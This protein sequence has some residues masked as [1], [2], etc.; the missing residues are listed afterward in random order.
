MRTRNHLALLT[1]SASG[2]VLLTSCKSPSID[3]Q[4]NQLALPYPAAWT[5]SDAVTPHTAD[6]V[7]DIGLPGL[8]TVV[9]EALAN[10]QDLAAAAA[11]MD[12]ALANA[13]AANGQR[14]PAIGAGLSRTRSRRASETFDFPGAGAGVP[15]STEVEATQNSNYDLLANLSWE[16]D[17]WGRLRDQAAAANANYEATL[18]DLVA[19]E[20][21]IAANAAILWI[22]AAAANE[23][24]DLAEQTVESFEDNLR[25]IEDRY[26][27]GVTGALDVRLARTNV[28]NAQANLAVQRRQRDGLLR[29]L[30]TILGRYPEAEAAVLPSRPLFAT[31]LAQLSEPV[32]A[33]LP[34]GLLLRRPDLQSAERRL[35]A[36]E[37]NLT[38]TKKTRLPNISLTTAGGTSTSELGDL[39]DTDFRFWSLG[40]D[41]SVPIFQGGRISANIDRAE[42][43]R[44]EALANF[45]Q[46]ALTAFREVETAL[47]AGEFLADLEEADA[48]AVSES[49]AAEQLA[50]DQYRGGIVD[51]ITVLEAQ[52]RLF[53]SR[54]QLIASR[55]ERLQ[56]RINLYLALGGSPD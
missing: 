23:Q 40:L 8:E 48:L 52:R 55:S 12:Q 2:I 5:G 16:I 49:E 29:S 31:T 18:N 42:G 26:N 1:A 7:A 33:G 56:N 53:N 46:T 35:A 54:S 4:H 28:A 19:A 38:S 17:L 45:R 9:S 15:G 39:T 14:Q 6:W 25:V 10:N 43:E 13:R 47:A 21:S 51:I 32:P 11:R 22:Q 34:S 36:T 3:S 37:A 30:E 27:A 20:F 41:A 50:L 24:I 44:R